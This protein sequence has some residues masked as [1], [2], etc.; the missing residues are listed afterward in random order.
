LC[1]LRKLSILP[2]SDGNWVNT[3]T[4][5]LLSLFRA[6]PDLSFLALHHMANYPNDWSKLFGGLAAAA[7]RL[8]GLSCDNCDHLPLRAWLAADSQLRCL[9]LRRCQFERIE[10]QSLEVVD[11][12]VPALWRQWVHSMHTLERVTIENVVLSIRSPD[13]SLWGLRYSHNVLEED[14]MDE[15]TTAVA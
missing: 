15:E 4:Q 1:K 8:V 13:P 3:A 12:E 2:I 5:D 10:C 7:P 6:M 14:V 11:E 9:S